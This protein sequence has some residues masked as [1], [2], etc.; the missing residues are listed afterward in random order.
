MSQNSFFKRQIRL[1]EPFKKKV[2]VA[3]IV[4]YSLVA[5]VFIFGFGAFSWMVGKNIDEIYRFSENYAFGKGVNPF[6]VMLGETPSS[7]GIEISERAGTAPYNF[8]FYYLFHF[9]DSN[10]NI[11]MAV[12]FCFYVAALIGSSAILFRFIRKRTCG[13]ILLAAFVVLVFGGQYGVGVA[14]GM[15]NYSIYSYF[16][17]LLLVYTDFCER[18]PVMGGLLLGLGMMKPQMMMPFFVPLVIRRKFLVVF[19]S[20]ALVSVAYFAACAIIY[21][22]PIDLFDS[23]SRQGVA[24]TR[25]S[26]VYCGLISS[27]GAFVSGKNSTDFLNISFVVFLMLTF[28][29]SWRFGNMEN[30]YIYLIPA[31]IS[32]IWSYS[33]AYNSTGIYILWAVPIVLDFFAREKISIGR[34]LLYIGVLAVMVFYLPRKTLGLPNELFP[35]SEDLYRLFM[36]FAAFFIVAKRNTFITDYGKISGGGRKTLQKV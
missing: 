26:K 36:V 1:S 27:I 25:L 3:M 20:V 7:C 2:L 4:F 12:A 23:F 30:M 5:A 24:A 13:N 19:V 8:V 34:L 21:T 32:T 15:G 22:N 17:I 33:Y 31:A 28:V 35:F 6:A 9:S 29:L 11:A 14:F 10:K 16:F 18:Q